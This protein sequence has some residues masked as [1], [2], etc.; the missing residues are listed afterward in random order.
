RHQLPAMVTYK[1]K[2]V[3]PDADPHFAGVFTNAAIEQA[4]L[5]H[6]DLLIGVGLDPVELLPRPWRS[7]QPIVYCG[8]W[9]VETRHVPF[10]AQLI[11]DT[12]V[13]L[14]HIDE[15]LGESTWSLDAVN[16]MVAAQRTAAFAPSQTLSAHQVVKAAARAFP[17]AR[18]SIDAGAHMLP[19][20]MLWP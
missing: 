19:A 16:R 9:P 14:R 10:A 18:V 20:T 15:A 7:R 3:V 13:G 12:A 8:P 5:E 2:G 4:M 1:A 11:G 17:Y 6:A